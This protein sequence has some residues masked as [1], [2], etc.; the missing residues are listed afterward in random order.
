MMD[1]TAG[2]SP[3]DGARYLNIE[4]YR[5]N[6]A[7]VRT[8]VWFAISPDAP[9]GGAPKLYIYSTASSGKA[10]R[11]RRSS[12]VRIA[13]CDMR[14][15]VTG[16]W[17][18]ARAEIVTGDDFDRGMGLLNLKYRPWKQLLAFMARLFSRDPRV[19]IAIWLI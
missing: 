17:V 1:T 3:F 11:I 2:L 8:P 10:K 13:P 7:G 6:G 5:K 9:G 19:V 4:T 15:K 16:E 12:V 18:D 14:G